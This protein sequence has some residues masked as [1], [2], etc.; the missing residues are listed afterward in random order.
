VTQYM[1]RPNILRLKV[2]QLFLWISTQLVDLDI[3]RTCMFNGDCDRVEELLCD[4][5]Q[6]PDLLKSMQYR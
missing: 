6:G 4:E 3:V 1:Y 2:S 5:G